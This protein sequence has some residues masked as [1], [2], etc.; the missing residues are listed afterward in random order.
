MPKKMTPAERKQLYQETM[1]LI[2]YA[3]MLNGWQEELE[4]TCPGT[5]ERATKI[6][7]MTKQ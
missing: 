5:K 4:I 1:D 7:K 3:K 2:E 6:T